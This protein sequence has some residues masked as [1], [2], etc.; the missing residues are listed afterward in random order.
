MKF[1]LFLKILLIFLKKNN[2]SSNFLQTI[3]IVKDKVAIWIYD[4]IQK[5]I[6]GE[7]NIC[8]KV[9]QFPSNLSCLYISNL[10]IILY[11]MNMKIR[12]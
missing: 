12:Y 1:N 10:L 8:L 9:T 6:G 7:F 11:N 5:S 2:H 3:E 4:W